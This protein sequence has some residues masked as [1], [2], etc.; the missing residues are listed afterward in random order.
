MKKSDFKLAFDLIL[1]GTL[2]YTVIQIMKKGNGG[3]KPS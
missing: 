3:T 1:A 2:M